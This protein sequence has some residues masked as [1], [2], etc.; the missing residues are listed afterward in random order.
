VQAL[1]VVSRLEKLAPGDVVELGDQL[2][3]VDATVLGH[4]ILGHG[5]AKSA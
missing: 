1:V 3:Q 4:I 2:D 5:K